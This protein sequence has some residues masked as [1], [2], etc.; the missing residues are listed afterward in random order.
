MK[1]LIV[2]LIFGILLTPIFG[3]FFMNH[4]MGKMDNMDVCPIVAFLTLTCS[5]GVVPMASQHISAFLS[6]SN[7]PITPFLSFAIILALAVF[8]WVHFRL[9]F[10][11][12]VTVSASEQYC[13]HDFRIIQLPTTKKFFNWLSLLEN[14]PSYIQ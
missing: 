2:F 6:F 14:S 9:R 4:E 12:L 13:L 7:N 8:T 10:L 5:V 3:L 11:S 1:Y